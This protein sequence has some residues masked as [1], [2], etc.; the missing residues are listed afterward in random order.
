MAIGRYDAPFEEFKPDPPLTEAFQIHSLLIKRGIIPKKGK[1]PLTLELIQEILKTETEL[2]EGGIS[3]EGKTLKELGDYLDI[4]FKLYTSYAK[5]MDKDIEVTPRFIDNVIMHEMVSLIVEGMDL[6]W[7]SGLPG[8]ARFEP[9]PTQKYLREATKKEADGEHDE[10]LELLN[11]AVEIR[12]DIE[13]LLDRGFFFSNHKQID[14]AIA[15][16]SLGI[17]ECNP[18]DNNFPIAYLRRALCYAQKNM[19]DNVIDDMIK[20]FTWYYERIK[21][22]P[23]MN[24][25][26][27]LVVGGG[28]IEFFLEECVPAIKLIDTEKN[29]KLSDNQKKKISELKE[30][31]LAIRQIADY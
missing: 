11:K 21:F 29:V 1:T 28:S 3:K 12:A 19:V 18:F 22:K 17:K 14:K 9:S 20:G 15:D 16:Y 2:S 27:Q 4:A 26:D 10:A 31:V 7:K 23:K 25:N 30:M 8:T 24:E 6:A 5:W 13:P